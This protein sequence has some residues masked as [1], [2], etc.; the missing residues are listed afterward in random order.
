MQGVAHMWNGDPGAARRTL[1]RGQTLAEQIGA[2]F[3]VRYVRI[4]LAFCRATCEE[5]PPSPELR[6]LAEALHEEA[7]PR[8]GQPA[9]LAHYILA[10][11]RLR[12]G[13]LGSAECAARS[14]LTSA[15]LAPTN[16]LL[17]YGTLI[18][19]LLRQGRVS[20]ARA[21]AEEGLQLRSS[22]QGHPRS[23][24]MLRLAAARA[25]YADRSLEGARLVLH[26]AVVELQRRAST[27]ADPE[28]RA[29]YLNQVPEHARLRAL[30]GQW[31]TETAAAVP[32]L[33]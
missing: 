7:T 29:R 14:L 20:D 25:R 31:S 1:V 22:L 15:D 2:E 24:I 9:G 30:A 26:E 18:E 32:L 6:A 28:A 12:Q 19:I 4:G 27:C 5:G 11:V 3:L 21:L 10:C 33:Q 13:E 23:E 8:R 17:C 16:R